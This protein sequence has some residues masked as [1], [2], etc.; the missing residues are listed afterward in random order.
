MIEDIDEVKESTASVM[1]EETRSKRKV[2][3][4][5][6]EVKKFEE[7]AKKALEANNEDDARIFLSKKQEVENVGDGYATAYAEDHENAVKMS[8]MHDKIYKDIDTLQNRRTMIK[9]NNSVS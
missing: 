1:A 4:N 2:D 3:E 9:G 6:A 5:E 7:L 8:Q